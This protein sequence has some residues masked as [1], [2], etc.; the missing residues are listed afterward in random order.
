MWSAPQL[1]NGGGGALHRRAR[2]CLTVVEVWSWAPDGCFVPRRTDRL[3]V[4]RNMRL[5]STSSRMRDTVVGGVLYS[6]YFEFMRQGIVQ[7]PSR[8]W[9]WVP[10]TSTVALRVV[11]G[12]GK[13]TQCLGV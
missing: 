12:D 3:D 7:W 13:G 1:Y 6:V 5:D 8:A 10:I 2:D 11:K 9:R 4:G